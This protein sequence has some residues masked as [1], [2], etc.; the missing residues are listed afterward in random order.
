LANLQ[1]EFYKRAVREVLSETT[2]AF[3]KEHQLHQPIE[4]KSLF[5]LSGKKI[6]NI[7]EVPKEC[8]IL[9]AS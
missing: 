4:M 2:L 9:V 5:L 8:K 6:D 7:L 3:Q 1:I